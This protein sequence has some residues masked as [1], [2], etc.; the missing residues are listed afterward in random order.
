MPQRLWRPWF[1]APLVLVVDIVTKRLVL[2]NIDA[3]RGRV[4]VIGDFARF[5]YVRN[6]GRH[7]FSLGEPSR[8]FDYGQFATNQMMRFLKT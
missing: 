3:L 1:W 5:I 2:A 4:E 6:Q 7:G 8:A